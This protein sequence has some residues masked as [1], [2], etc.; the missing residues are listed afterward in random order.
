[1][2]TT[3]ADYTTWTTD[4]LTHTAAG[5]VHAINAL[6]YAD[7]ERAKGLALDPSDMDTDTAVA[8]RQTMLDELHTRALAEYRESY[9]GRDRLRRDMASDH[10][11]RM[12]HRLDTWNLDGYHRACMRDELHARAL[13]E[14]PTTRDT[15]RETAG[16]FSTLEIGRLLDTKWAG[17]WTMDGW[18]RACLMDELHDRALKDTAVVEAAATVRWTSQDSVSYLADLVRE[19]GLDDQDV[20]DIAASVDAGE[21]QYVGRG[22]Q[23]RVALAL[24]ASAVSVSAEFVAGEVV[25]ALGW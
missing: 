20:A 5:W 25:A 10:T 4:E 11:V 6:R 15:T 8:I 12:G 23:F 14:Y 19:E 16:T 21:V 9:T 24:A 3:T 13:R 1:M 22:Q 18:N 17:G 7:S 2:T